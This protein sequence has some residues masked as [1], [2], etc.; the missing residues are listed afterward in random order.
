MEAYKLCIKDL[1]SKFCSKKTGS[2]IGWI[3]CILFGIIFVFLTSWALYGQLCKHKENRDQSG[4]EADGIF[5]DKENL[6]WEAF[7]KG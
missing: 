2:R 6:K 1:S 5:Q 7:A 4:Y 3:N